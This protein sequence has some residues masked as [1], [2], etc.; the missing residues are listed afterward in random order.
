MSRDRVAVVGAGIAGLATA[1]RLAPLPV[2]LITAAPL[3]EGTATA[4]AQG[5]IAAALG[6]DD[7]PA[8]HA[9]DTLAAG[10]GLSEQE[11]AQRVAAA[12]PALV[13]W[14][15]TLGVG[16]DR[17][18]GGAL[19]LG[20]EAAHGRRR[21]VKAGGDATGL[22]VLRALQRAVAASPAIDVV[23][24]SAAALRRDAGGRVAG[25]RAVR[26][27]RAVDLGAR[28]V[29]LATGGIGAL[30]RD[31]TN[32]QGA[33]GEGIALAARAG[34]IL[35][36]VEFV[37]FH[38]TAIAV[39]GGGPLPLATEALRGEGAVLV[40]G[41]GA[42]VMAGIAGGDLAPRD[43][44][45]RAIFARTSRGERVFLDARGT[46]VARRFPTVAALCRAAGIDPASTPIPVRP[47]AH[48]HMGGIRVDARGRASL[49]GLWAC[50]EVACTG[51]HGAN[52]LASNSLLEALA[53]A[54]WI[55]ADLRG[56]EAAGRTALEP[57]AGAAPG[58]GTCA[59][60]RD[61][62]A[63]AVGVVRDAPGLGRALARL[64]ALDAAG[65]PGASVALLVAAAA[66]RRR[67]SRGAHWRADHPA[68][69]APRH[70][71]I[72]LGEARR[73]AETLAVEEVR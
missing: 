66:L 16:F 17:G 8:L 33:F 6:A 2:T 34:A 65:A 38:P 71:D 43:V 20:L 47:A 63:G 9:A 23:V 29:V 10:A 28:A 45:A 54:D 72:T 4:W 61:L 42:R 64:A 30:Y 57:V 67:E 58:R 25:L 19:A 68:Q 11:V 21:I 49:P 52:R 70:A 40:D 5:G 32:P 13:G 18:R 50:G 1:L 26:D 60:I 36:D 48:Y 27:G 15:A 24:A 44:V 39:S 35:R 12:G 41:A 53:F 69:E 3:G 14:L 73:L 59:E 22:A 62:M 31:T 51:L 37:Q 56:S 46:E 55:A 7:A